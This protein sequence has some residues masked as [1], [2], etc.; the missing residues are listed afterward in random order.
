MLR[1][2]ESRGLPSPQAAGEQHGGQDGETV[3]LTVSQELALS[4][5]LQKSTKEGL[6][7][8]REG[9]AEP[10]PT[11]QGARTLATKA[12]RRRRAYRRLNRTVAEVV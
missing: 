12:L 3:A 4:P 10:A 5:L 2:P 1:E 6:G 7:A 9:A 8:V 11:G